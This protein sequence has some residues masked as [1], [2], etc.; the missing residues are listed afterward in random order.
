MQCVVLLSVAVT[1]KL[2]VPVTVGVPDTVPVEE[3][4]DKLRPVGKL[5]LVTAYVIGAVPPV[6]TIFW[7]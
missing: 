3:A 5:P 6:D 7:L 4:D 2:K 1:V